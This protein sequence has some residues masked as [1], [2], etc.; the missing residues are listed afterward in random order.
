[1][2]IALGFRYVRDILKQSMGGA[3]SEPILIGC[4]NASGAQA[5]RHGI[6]DA[7]LEKDPQTVP[8][9]GMSCLSP[10]RED[11]FQQI[12]ELPP[13]LCGHAMSSVAPLYELCLRHVLLE[14]E[15]VFDAHQMIFVSDDNRHFRYFTGNFA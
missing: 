9:L 1:M 14:V 11:P 10:F 13:L 6:G 5:M 3:Y 7:T 2:P 15:A 12:I 8:R 4:I